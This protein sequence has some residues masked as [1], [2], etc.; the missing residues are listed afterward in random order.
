M[1]G[2]QSS[3]HVGSPLFIAHSFVNGLS[4]LLCLDFLDGLSN[5][6][7]DLDLLFF[8]NNNLLF[9]VEV[10]SSS[11]G[12][13]NSWV[14]LD[15]SLSSILCSIDGIFLGILFG[16]IFGDLFLGLRSCS[17]HSMYYF[18][19]ISKLFSDNLLGCLGFFDDLG[20]LLLSNNRISFLLDLLFLNYLGLD[21]LFVVLGCIFLDFNRGRLELLFIFGA[22]GT[23]LLT[24]RSGFGVLLDLLLVALLL[25]LLGKILDLRGELGS[26]LV[27]GHFFLILSLG[28]LLFFFSLLNDSLSLQGIHSFIV[29]D[30]LFVIIKRNS[31]VMARHMMVV[32]VSVNLIEGNG[33]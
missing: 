20:N 30:V 16:C 9:G 6:F 2:K 5:G 24:F 10:V 17:W 7:D 23:V 28:R 12:S 25:G 18:W 21:L 11:L 15:G 29:F 3:W 19:W 13:G 33:S 14:L 27:F 8:L 31:D 1:D 4:D 26:L 32:S 22:I